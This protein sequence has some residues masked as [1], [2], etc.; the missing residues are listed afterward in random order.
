MN[1]EQ[2]DWISKL[3][4]RELLELIGDVYYQDVEGWERD[5][6]GS[7]RHE[8]YA[9]ACSLGLA[10]DHGGILA[11]ELPFRCHYVPAR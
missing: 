10:K 11:A 5:E 6:I 2:Q 4:F 9:R 7:R 1:K 3:S 8:N